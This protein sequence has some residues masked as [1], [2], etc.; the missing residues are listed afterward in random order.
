MGVSREIRIFSN[1]EELSRVAAE[2]VLAFCKESSEERDRVYLV[3]SGGSTPQTLYRLLAQNPFREAMPW[4]DVHFFWGDERCVPPGDD[5]S[6][7]HHARRLLLDPIGVD[8]A[9]VHR[10]K[11]ELPPDSAA[12]DYEGLLR[13]IGARYGRGLRFDLVLMGLGSDGHVASLFPGQ[14]DH[15]QEERLVKAVEADYEDRAA[16]RV[17]L[18]PL[19][20]NNA[21]RILFLVSG[22]AKAQALRDT[23]EGKFDPLQNPSQR[24]HPEQGEVIWLVDQSAAVMLD[25]DQ[26]S[27][28]KP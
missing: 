27:I 24:I 10:I 4:K 20:F 18:T 12:L 3:L 9:N 14:I 25:E 1:L 8:P 17:T 21:K 16:R 7:Y 19:A 2:L 11:G 28:Y 6:N 22:E 13:K 23:L 5:Q 26:F 15:G